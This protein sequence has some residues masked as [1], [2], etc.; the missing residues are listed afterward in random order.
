MSDIYSYVPAEPLASLEDGVEVVKRALERWE[1]GEI[2]QLEGEIGSPDKI[3]KAYEVL[4]Q[5]NLN[6][7]D[8]KY[9][10]RNVDP[11]GLAERLDD[12]RDLLLNHRRA[13][14]MA[15][16]I[17]TTFHKEM[18]EPGQ[19]HTLVVNLTDNAN[20]D[21]ALGIYANMAN[22]RKSPLQRPEKLAL[23]C[24]YLNEMFGILGMPAKAVIMDYPATMRMFDEK[25]IEM[26]NALIKIRYDQKPRVFIQPLDKNLK[27]RTTM[28]SELGACGCIV[29]FG[30]VNALVQRIPVILEKVGPHAVYYLVDLEGSTSGV[31]ALSRFKNVQ[32]GK[33]SLVA[34]PR[35]LP[36]EV[37]PQLVPV[38]TEF[39]ARWQFMDPPGW[40]EVDFELKLAR[41][42]GGKIELEFNS[43]HFDEM[44]D[45][46]DIL[47]EMT[48]LEFTLT[49]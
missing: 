35:T 3:G 27:I 11:S 49:D 7:D 29:H 9:K 1:C 13:F 41:K 33:F 39:E 20:C 42:K 2:L 34:V 10:L 15:F 46:P 14:N 40:D 30:D 38:F 8:L 26:D 47:Q 23:T 16:A 4:N 44:P 21:A 19:D 32:G 24:N 43:T 22:L 25:T 12:F 28:Y 17:F 36:P 18:M 31:P 5:V 48:G 6:R 45:F 37:L